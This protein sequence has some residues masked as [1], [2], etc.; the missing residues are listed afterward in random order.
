MASLLIK[1]VPVHLLGHIDV[2]SEMFPGLDLQL[3]N[4]VF[5]NVICY[6]FNRPSSGKVLPVCLV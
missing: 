2:G 1:T 5:S 6:Y 3:S 4:F